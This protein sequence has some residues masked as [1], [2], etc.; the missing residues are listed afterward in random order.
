MG[1]RLNCNY[2]PKW[3]LNSSI[4]VLTNYA[5][6]PMVA[7]RLSAGVEGMGELMREHELGIQVMF[8]IVYIFREGKQVTNNESYM[9][10]NT[11]T[12]V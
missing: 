5:R 9:I 12:N 1:R 4:D 3:A 2:K 8:F 7:C 10:S 6:D 11:G